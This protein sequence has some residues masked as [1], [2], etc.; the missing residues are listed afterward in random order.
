L[1][2]DSPRNPREADQRDED[3]DPG[4]AEA[5][6]PTRGPGATRREETR[7]VLS[8]ARPLRPAVSHSKAPV[9]TIATATRCVML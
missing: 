7:S 6:E 4:D 2:A 5:C 9:P 1:G 3:E 8:E